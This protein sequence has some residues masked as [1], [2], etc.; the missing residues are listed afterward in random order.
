MKPISSIHGT[1]TP[2]RTDRRWQWCARRVRCHIIRHTPV[3]KSAQGQSSDGSWGRQKT[4]FLKYLAGIRLELKG[5]GESCS[6]VTKRRRCVATPVYPFLALLAV[7]IPL[8]ASSKHWI[9]WVVCRRDCSLSGGIV[10]NQ[11][12][13]RGHRHT[14]IV[15]QLNQS[16]KQ[17]HTVQA[18]MTRTD[19]LRASPCT[20]LHHCK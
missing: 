4:G 18:V 1:T 14:C 19:C 7:A 2:G 3:A 8:H 13:A 16:V 11:A 15:F 20:F 12:V 10:A 9:K 17:N 6:L 5:C